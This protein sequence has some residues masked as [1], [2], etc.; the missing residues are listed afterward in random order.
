MT[1]LIVEDDFVNRLV[2]QKRLEEHGEVHIAVN[3]AEAVDAVMRMLD[4]GA[5]YDLICLDIMLPGMDGHEALKQIRAAEAEKGF[6]VGEGSRI[7]MTTAL[8]DAE[9]VMGAFR[10]EADG[11][12]VKPIEP[13]KLKEQLDQLGLT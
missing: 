5:T 10:L 6:R 13:E 9:N 8:R 4:D 12:L 3:G 7:I 11:Y 2:L 1:T